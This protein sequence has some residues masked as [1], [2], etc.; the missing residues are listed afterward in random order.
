MKSARIDKKARVLSCLFTVIMLQYLSVIYYE[1]SIIR[2]FYIQK[3]TKIY[4]P[5][6]YYDDFYINLRCC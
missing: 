6:N 2:Q 1:N 5:V 3:A 4:I